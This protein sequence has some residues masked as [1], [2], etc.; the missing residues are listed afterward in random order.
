[1]SGDRCSILYVQTSGTESPE[2]LYAPFILGS[3]AAAMDIDVTIYFLIRGVTAVKEGE[4]EG[5]KLG[6]FPSL[7]EVMDRAIEA[8]VRLLVCE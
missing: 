1:M 3:T 4:A 8:G 5:I 7:K 6:G 2:R